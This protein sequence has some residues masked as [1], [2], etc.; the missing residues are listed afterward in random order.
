MTN[1]REIQIFDG[2]LIFQL[3]LLFSINILAKLTF[4][5]QNFEALFNLGFITGLSATLFPAYY[6]MIPL[7]YVVSL[8]QT[9]FKVRELLLYIAGCVIPQLFIALWF[10]YQNKFGS[11]PIKSWFILSEHIPLNYLFD[12]VVLLATTFFSI[13][14]SRDAISN[15]AL[16]QKKVASSINSLLILWSIFAVFMY[17]RYE[18]ILFLQLI[19]IPLTFI[20]SISLLKSKNSFILSFTFLAALVFSYFKFF[21]K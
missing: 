11:F 4:N 15:L 7:V 12:C 21:F 1:T 14:Y 9:S 13:L 8:F 10:L 20:T 19:I 17:F 16:A 2:A 6:V 18:S 5:K 3:L